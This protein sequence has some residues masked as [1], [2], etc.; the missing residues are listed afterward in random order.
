MAVINSNNA[1]LVFNS[2]DLS[3]R[4]I[5]EVDKSE[6]NSTVDTTSGAGATH[7][8]RNPGLSDNTISFSVEADDVEFNAYK[9]ALVVGTKATLVYGPE[10]AVSG[11]P[12]FE[13]V[14]I[15]KSVSGANATI[16]KGVHQ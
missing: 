12:K 16:E 9:S 13:C 7:V 14:C 10:G 11:K 3:A 2:I 6:E 4:W 8:M 5:G 1:S 15:L